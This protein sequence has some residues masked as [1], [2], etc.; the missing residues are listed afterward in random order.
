MVVKRNSRQRFNIDPNEVV[1]DEMGLHTEESNKSKRPSTEM[2]KRKSKEFLITVPLNRNKR[3]RSNRINSADELIASE[4]QSKEYCKSEVTF[5]KYKAKAVTNSTETDIPVCELADPNGVLFSPIYCLLD[6]E[7]AGNTA[8]I[9][10]DANQKLICNSTLPYAAEFPTAE[11]AEVAEDWDNTFDPYFFIKHLPPLTSEMRARGPA[12]PLK[13]RSSPE[14][15]LVLDLDETLVHCSLEKLED[16]SFSFPVLFQESEYQVYVRTRPFIVEF[17]ERVSKLFE[18]IIFTA[19]KKVYA[20]HLLNL[21]DPKRKLIKY[22]LYREH[23]VCIAGNYIKDLTVL[24]RDLAKTIIIDNSPQAFGYQ[25]ENG[26]P[27]ESWFADKGDNE[28]MKLVPFLESLAF[29]NEDV[30]PHIRRK[31]HL[32]SF[33]PPD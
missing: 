20:Q 28:L 17:L 18:I 16:A 26:I 25:L 21:L 15:T 10:S 30:R 5:E 11:E 24:G 13:T 2:C 32:S 1:S 19:S 6:E 4:K 22:R 7:T 12:L 8:N 14:F 3:R 23:C 29:M 31:Y 9:Q 33:L 27:I